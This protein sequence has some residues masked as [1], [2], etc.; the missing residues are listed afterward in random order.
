MSEVSV[1]LADGFEE[2]E[3]L[4]VV[5]LLKRA[6]I[7]VEMVSIMDTDH[8]IGRSHIPVI[9]DT[10]FEKADFKNTKM[11]VLPGGQPGTKY[12]TAHEGLKKLLLQFNEEG[13]RI[14]AICAAPT[15]LGAHGILKGKKA[16]CYPGCEDGLV[17]ADVVVSKEVVTDGNITTSRGAGTAINFALHLIKKLRDKEVAEDVRKGI[18]FKTTE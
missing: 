1:F 13:K 18:V 7:D 6:D 15:V 12:L 10:T 17:G 14:A 9:A 16:T 2:V 8:V 11:L 4:T 3:A 5:D